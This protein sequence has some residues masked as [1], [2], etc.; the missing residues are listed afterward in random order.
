M[1]NMIELSSIYVDIEKLDPT[2]KLA[3]E[4]NKIFDTDNSKISNASYI[5]KKLM[6]IWFY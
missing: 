4:G 3:Y 5:I 2:G 1:F 6:K